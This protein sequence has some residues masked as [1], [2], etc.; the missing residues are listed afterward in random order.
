MSGPFL[1]CKL[2]LHETTFSEDELVIASSTGLQ[3]APGEYL[4]LWQDGRKVL[5]IQVPDGG[6]KSLVS[7][8][9]AVSVLRQLAS[10]LVK[11]QDVAVRVADVAMCA[12]SFVELSFKDLYISQS[13][14]WQLKSDLVGMTVHAGKMLRRGMAGEV[15]ELRIGS[16]T[17]SSGIVAENTKFI[18]RSCS[19]R[20]F[21]L[22]PITRELWGF[23]D[24]STL[25]HERV[26]HFLSSLMAKW[27]AAPTGVTHSLTVLFF[28]RVRYKSEALPQLLLEELGGTPAE[29][30]CFHRDAAGRVYADCYRTIIDNETEPDW[31]ALVVR[32]R[33][34]LAV[35]T[36]QMCSAPLV[37]LAPHLAGRLEGAE[38]MLC[39]GLPSSLEESG[40]LEAI[41]LVITIFENEHMDRDLNRTNNSILLFTAGCGVFHVDPELEQVTKQRLMDSGIGMDV[42]CVA[43]PPLHQVPLFVHT[44]AQQARHSSG[45]GAA[46]RP[47]LDSCAESTAAATQHTFSLPVW[48]NLSFYRPR[49]VCAPWGFSQ[50]AGGPDRPDG[51][52]P[53]R[54]AEL[55][56]A[57]F[58]PLPESQL[59]QHDALPLPLAALFPHSSAGPAPARQHSGASARGSQLKRKPRAAVAGLVPDLQEGDRFGSVLSSSFMAEHDQN[60]FGN[61]AQKRGDATAPSKG[62]RLAATSSSSSMM[63][64][65]MSA[66]NLQ[67]LSRNF[68]QGARGRSRGMPQPPRTTR[69]AD[70]STHGSFKDES[71]LQQ[72][73]HTVGSY[74]A[75]T[76]FLRGGPLSLASSSSSSS[77]SASSASQFHHGGTMRKRS[78]PSTGAPR[79]ELAPVA[80]T[81]PFLKS[82]RDAVRH[83]YTS[84][85]RRWSQIFPS[86][87]EHSGYDATHAIPWKSLLMPALLPTHTDYH[88]TPTELREHYVDGGLYDVEPPEGMDAQQ[89]LTELV[90]QR[91]EQHF[92]IV[93]GT[94]NIIFEARE[95]QRIDGGVTQGSAGSVSFFLSK[96]HRIHQLECPPHSTQVRVKIRT[97]RAS[98]EDKRE[99]PYRY[100]VWVPLQQ[101]FTP[102]AMSFSKYQ[103]ESHSWS[104]LDSAISDSADFQYDFSQFSDKIR[105]RRIRAS[106]VP[107]HPDS[108]SSDEERAALLED[109]SLRLKR[110]IEFLDTKRPKGHAPVIVAAAAAPESMAAIFKPKSR[111]LRV[112][113]S[114]KDEQ[115]SEWLYCCYD[116]EFSPRECWHLDVH[117]FACSATAVDKFVDLL[118]RKATQ[119]GL[120]LVE[121]VEFSRQDDVLRSVNPFRAPIFLPAARFSRAIEEALTARFSFVGDGGNNQTRNPYRQY[122]HSTVPVFVRRTT[123]RGG[124]A[125]LI[126]M[127]SRSALTAKWSAAT[128]ALWEEL[129]IYIAAVVTVGG[130][131][132]SAATSLLL[133]PWRRGQNNE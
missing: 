58:V 111:V 82:E 133:R 97:Q 109:Y 131:M 2:L 114:H 50:H 83:R 76:G 120:Q 14:V 57:A 118:K 86:A 89:L 85:R 37:S 18:F 3:L 67:D 72:Q 32:V 117:W 38:Q 29:P 74:E 90:V 104:A 71:P 96:G 125:Q 48:V 22:L 15:N 123:S 44:H 28:S 25:L 70:S 81:N 69:H 99:H 93:S 47:S 21:C 87:Q 30:S 62:S 45:G 121:V 84:N 13:D 7:Q 10:H 52:Q 98:A 4:E 49:D 46:A 124:A 1:P 64:S 105:M 129:C 43:P 17:V 75:P 16:G 39:E 65:T 88:P 127:N 42:V 106:V 122:K 31:A 63:R 92:Q 78:L 41:N 91:L 34:E 12:L 54:G 79:A 66:S 23:G 108:C 94:K 130:A 128:R 51:E 53:E 5:V 107:P 8:R 35:C 27:T 126:W 132:E 100:A 20:F 116:E 119:N 36:Q 56:D 60:V 77:S 19:A 113:T 68:S 61:P 11:S 115:R 80:F 24:D 59:L 9:P 6:D 101:H 73:L 102:M 103:G 55:D 95:A 26:E 110:F 40:F 33:R 112:P